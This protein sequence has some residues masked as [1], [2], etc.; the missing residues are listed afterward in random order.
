MLLTSGVGLISPEALTYSI[1]I[2]E[3][4]MGVLH[5]VSDGLSVSQRILSLGLL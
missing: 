1:S 5:V 2:V 3:E 4:T